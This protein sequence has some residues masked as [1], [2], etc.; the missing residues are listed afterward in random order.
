MVIPLLFTFFNTNRGKNVEN[1]LAKSVCRFA[2]QAYLGCTH[3]TLHLNIYKEGI[4]T[5]GR[6]TKKEAFHKASFSI[7]NR[8]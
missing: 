4:E 7:F 3:N 2:H 6:Y 8:Y 5:R 1:A